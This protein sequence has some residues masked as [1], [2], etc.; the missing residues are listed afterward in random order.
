MFKFLLVVGIL[1][2]VFSMIFLCGSLTV[3]GISDD[4]A[5]A[6][7]LMEDLLCRDNEIYSKDTSSRIDSDG[8]NY[9][10]M[11][12]YCQAPGGAVRNVTAQMVLLAGAG[13]AIP[14]VIGLI[15]T[16]LSIMALVRGK[17]RS[18]IPTT[19]VRS[20]SYPITPDVPPFQQAGN[21]SWQTTLDGITLQTMPPTV[22]PT[23]TDKLQQ[24]QDALARGLITP[25]EYNAARK[26]IL[27][28]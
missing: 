4:N 24:I 7:T 16:V 18:M 21:N 13:F 19:T 1:L 27:E 14:F 22:E 28:D 15:L 12:M 20:T 3:A 26:R 6:H 8:S 2:E 9:Q 5:K 25:D 11:D 23:L 17:V 10:S